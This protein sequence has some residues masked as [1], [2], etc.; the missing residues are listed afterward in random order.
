MVFFFHLK[1]PISRDL[2]KHTLA[3]SHLLVSVL[4]FLLLWWLSLAI[5]KTKPSKCILSPIPSPLLPDRVPV[6]FHFMSWILI[7]PLCNQSFPSGKQYAD[8]IFYFKKWKQTTLPKSLLTSHFFKGSM[9]PY[10]SPLI[11]SQTCSNQT[12]IPSTPDKHFLEM[13]PIIWPLFNLVIICLSFSCA[14]NDFLHTQSSLFLETLSS[15]GFRI[16]S[17][18]IFFL[19]HYLSSQLSM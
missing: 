13:L 8:I 4:S 18:V 9:V 10:F 3:L 12:F 11:L 16:P 14:I 6:V 1:R 7:S 5:D 19:L 17:H 15:L 2:L